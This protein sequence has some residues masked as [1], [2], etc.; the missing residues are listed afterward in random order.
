MPTWVL[1]FGIAVLF[2]VCFIDEGIVPAIAKAGRLTLMIS[3]AA[4]LITGAVAYFT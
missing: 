3:M 2:S 1:V 4:F